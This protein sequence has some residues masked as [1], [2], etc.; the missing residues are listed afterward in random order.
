MSHPHSAHTPGPY[1]DRQEAARS[2][3]LDL[4]ANQCI[5]DDV[6]GDVYEG[7]LSPRD[8]AMRLGLGPTNGCAAYTVEDAI[9]EAAA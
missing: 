1:I 2:W 4:G 7:E 9:F 8:A 3:L 6:L 5:L